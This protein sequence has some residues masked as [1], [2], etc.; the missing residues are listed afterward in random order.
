MSWPERGTIA[1]TQTCTYCAIKELATLGLIERFRGPNAAAVLWLP[2]TLLAPAWAARAESLGDLR[3]GI[4]AQAIE[5]D[6]GKPAGTE[7]QPPGCPGDPPLAVWDYGD[8][9]LMLVVAGQGPAAQLFSVTSFADN[10][11]TTEKGVALGS[12]L[13]QAVAAYPSASDRSPESFRVELESGALELSFSGEQPPR[14]TSIRLTAEPR[15]V[16]EDG[17]DCGRP[18]D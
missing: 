18:A 17:L 11:L 12:T 2:L 14:V 3:L 13:G 6:L 7:D 15:R 5:Q 16:Y 1:S 8:R 4:T 9:G 10:R